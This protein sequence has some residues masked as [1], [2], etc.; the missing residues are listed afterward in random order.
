MASRDLAEMRRSGCANPAL[1]LSAE[2]SV[3]KKVAA[4]VYPLERF[5]G[6][7]EL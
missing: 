6:V 4:L 2:I 5:A 3:C 7:T 1:L